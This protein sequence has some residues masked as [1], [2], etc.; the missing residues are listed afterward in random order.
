MGWS[1][2][3]D[4]G[5]REGRG[6][7]SPTIPGLEALS[8]LPSWGGEFVGTPELALL[9]DSTSLEGRAVSP[10]LDASEGF[11]RAPWNRPGHMH[12]FVCV[13][14][15]CEPLL[16][17]RLGAASSSRHGP[18]I[19]GTTAWRGSFTRFL[20]LLPLLPPSLFHMAS[21]GHLCLDARDQR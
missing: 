3:T 1:L 4:L 7:E 16:Q 2:P 18:C 15:T 21:L 10:G 14:I 13:L 19:P 11:W 5:S 9:W 6:C 20:A 17:A 12:S 8:L